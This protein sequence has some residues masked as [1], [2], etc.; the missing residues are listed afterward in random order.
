M[1]YTDDRCTRWDDPEAKR[2]EE[3]TSDD[4]GDDEDTDR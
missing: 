2:G 3:S 1:R 4:Q